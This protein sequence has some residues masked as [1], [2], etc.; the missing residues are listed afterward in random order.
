MSKPEFLL[1]AIALLPS[2]AVDT[3]SPEGDIGAS[4]TASRTSGPPGSAGQGESCR[5]GQACRTGLTCVSF[6]GFGGNQLATCEIPCEDGAACSEGQRCTLIVDGPGWV[7]QA[8]GGAEGVGA[9]DEPLPQ[10]GQPCPEGRCE[11]GLA[12]IEYYGIA[13]P[14]GGTFTSCEIRCRADEGCPAEQ[15]C[16]TIMDGPGQVCRW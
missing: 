4:P 3:V 5:E 7:C 10:Q 13:G 14:R 2:C 11:A 9:G 1:I 15:R 6:V 16:V 12:C 8:G